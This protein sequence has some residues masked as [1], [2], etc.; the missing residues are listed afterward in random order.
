MFAKR[1]C[2][3]LSSPANH[4]MERSDNRRQ[5]ESRGCLHTMPRCEGGKACVAGLSPLYRKGVWGIGNTMFAKRIC[6]TLSSP[7]NL[8]VN[9]IVFLS[10]E[11]WE[12]RTCAVAALSSYL[13]NIDF[14]CCVFHILTHFF[15]RLKIYY[16]LLQCWLRSE[17]R[18]T[19]SSCNILG[20]SCIVDI[21]EP[22]LLCEWS[23][24]FSNGRI[25]IVIGTLF[26]SED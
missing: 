13:I 26:L 19:I 18:T 10:C 6:G 11:A 20:Y 15:C 22:V 2:G 25:T 24:S 5:T 12:Q 7:A 4:L 8:L 1:I 21:V 23:Q 9:Q 14:R 3:T 17:Q 16:T